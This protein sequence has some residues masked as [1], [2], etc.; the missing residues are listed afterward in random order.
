MSPAATKLCAA[1]KAAQKGQAVVAGL[2]WESLSVWPPAE[3][4]W[5]A[6]SIGQSAAI[7]AAEAEFPDVAAG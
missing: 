5:W 1:E 7:K 2:P 4:A 6:T 3:V